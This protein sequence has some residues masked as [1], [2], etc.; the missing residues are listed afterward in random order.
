MYSRV[1]MGAFPFNTQG[2]KGVSFGLNH[3]QKLE[4]GEPLG[5]TSR[6]EDD[7]DAL[8]ED[9]DGLL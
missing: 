3:V 5:G 9:E 7:F 2:S 4:D 6:A 1:S 8:D